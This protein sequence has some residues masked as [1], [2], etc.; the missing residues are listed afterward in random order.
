MPKRHKEINNEHLNFLKEWVTLHSSMLLILSHFHLPL[1][2]TLKEYNEKIFLYLCVEIFSSFSSIFPKSKFK[3]IKHVTITIQV[4]HYI[5]CLFLSFY[6]K[7]LNALSWIV[8]CLWNCTLFTIFQRNR[9]GLW[10]HDIN[11][12]QLSYHYIMVLLNQ[13]QHLS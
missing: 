13:T 11:I 5:K 4:L 7:G 12:S 6:C 2:L 9:R 1:L 3:T 8:F 10:E